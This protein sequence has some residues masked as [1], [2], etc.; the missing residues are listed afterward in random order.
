M[1]GP[2]IVDD[3]VELRLD[4][5]LTDSEGGVHALTLLPCNSGDGERVI[6]SELRVA[7]SFPNKSAT[8]S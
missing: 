7:I 2:A 5:K 1:N 4:E 8:R 6:V 3:V